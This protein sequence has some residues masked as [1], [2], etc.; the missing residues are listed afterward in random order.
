MLFRPAGRESGTCTGTESFEARAFCQQALDLYRTNGG[1]G[2]SM[3]REIRGEILARL[4][5]ALSRDSRYAEALGWRAH[6][7]LDSLM[8]DPLPIADRDREMTQR[9]AGIQDDVARALQLD[10]GQGMALV[11]RARLDM[12]RWRLPDALAVLREASA[13]Q[14]RE[15]AVQHYMAMVSNLMG[16][17]AQAA[18]AARRALELDPR[19]PAPYTALVLALCAQGDH[20]GAIDAANSM[21]RSAPNTSIGYINL[22]RAEVAAGN[23]RAALEAVRIAEEKLGDMPN[24]GVEAALLYTSAAERAGAERML[25]QFLQKTAGLYVNPGLAA[26]ARI[27]AGDYA[28]ARELLE[29]AVRE[30]GSGMDPMPLLL[31]RLNLWGSPELEKTDW[32]ELRQRVTK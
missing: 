10:P 19:N 22:A 4:D 17:H 16:D 9:L 8:F 23:P 12:Y 29:Q 21:I 7:V 14:P 15:S 13:R 3:A 30:R 26:M 1:I 24:F 32:R 25:Q 6:V 31:L 27:A 11:A 28:Q 5:N 2:V 20:A 18:R